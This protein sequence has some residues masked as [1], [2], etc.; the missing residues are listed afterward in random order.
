[1]LINHL[2]KTQ[3]SYIYFIALLLILSSCKTKDEPTPVNY[4]RGRTINDFT[5]EPIE[6]VRVQLYYLDYSQSQQI[7]SIVIYQDTLTNAEGF[8]SFKDI[9]PDS[10]LNIYKEKYW[11]L[12]KFE[13]K[14]FISNEE[15]T[16]NMN[17]KMYINARILKTDTFWSNIQLFAIN[18][19]KGG[20]HFMPFDFK[21][22]IDSV[23]KGALIYENNYLLNYRL[24]RFDKD[25]FQIHNIPIHLKSLDTVDVTIEF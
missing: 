21:A 14:S 3:H 9:K 23:I 20:L 5:K 18:T 2:M 11:E 17:P 8:F 12:N 1:M 25:T 7:P 13:A 24:G 6:G 10:Y 4:V 22:K 19:K 15:K 16:V